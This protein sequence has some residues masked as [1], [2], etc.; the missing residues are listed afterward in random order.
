MSED[1]TLFAC[2]GIAV[3]N[4]G[5]SHESWPFSILNNADLDVASD[6]VYTA[7]KQCNG[8]SSLL[9]TATDPGTPTS[10]NKYFRA[11]MSSP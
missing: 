7:A 5:D 2:L 8:L 4:M 6:I 3:L 9:S 10:H 11:A 1:R